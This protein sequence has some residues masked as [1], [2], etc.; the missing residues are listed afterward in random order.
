MC[1]HTVY[2]IHPEDWKLYLPPPSFSQKA[3]RSP[4]YGP[5]SSAQEKNGLSTSI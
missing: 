3:G 5:Y 1:A 2:V 4:M